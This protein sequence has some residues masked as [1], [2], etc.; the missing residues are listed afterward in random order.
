M[1]MLLSQSIQSILQTLNQNGYQ[2]YVVGGCVRDALLG[3]EYTDIDICTNALP[4]V[5]QSLFE[6]TVPTGIRHGTITVLM[7]EP[8]EITTFRKES[9]YRDHRHPSTITFVSTIQEDLSRRDFTINA[10]AYHPDTGLIDPFGGRQDLKDHRI[11]CVGDP[12]TRFQ[13]DAL[14]LMRAHRFCAKLQFTM[15][16]N[17][18]AAL[19]RNAS[20]IRYIAVE[21]ICKELIQIL[22]WDP[23]QIEQMTELLSPWIPELEACLRCDQNSLWHDTN[24]LHHSLR[25]VSYLKPFDKELAYALLLHDIGKPSVKTTK[26]GIDHFYG[27]PPVSAAIA[28]R[29]VH[30]LKLPSSFQKEIPALIEFHDDG[31]ACK[32]KTIYRYRIE[33]GWSDQRMRQF[34]RL[35]QCDIL[36]HS[37]YGQKSLEDLNAFIE[38][39]NSQ[40]KRPMEFKDL[41]IGGKEVL[42]HTSQKG[43]AIHDTLKQLLQYVFYYPQKNQKEILISL[44]E[45]GRFV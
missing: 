39:Y 13:E 3:K 27:H 9:D 21:R 16:E 33:K 19:I 45:E 4:E 17:T 14:R 24:V 28:R 41:A 44:L 23:Y 10:M 25:A 6:H 2:A 36:A 35:R 31:L 1:N 26:E 8:V 37:S 12:D 32:L 11:R 34:F 7:P 22:E 43:R 42:E 5:V 18:K 40:S 15:E 38:Y 29:I 30:D 20:L